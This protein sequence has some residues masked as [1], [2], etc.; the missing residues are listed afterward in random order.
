M[1]GEG[2]VGAGVLL[3]GTTRIPLSFAYRTT[4]FK[5]ACE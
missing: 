3:T 4:S 2:A 1:S 5:S